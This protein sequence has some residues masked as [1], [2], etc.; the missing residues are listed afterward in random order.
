M[1]QGTDF[2][3]AKVNKFNMYGG[4]NG[5]KICVVLDGQNYMLKFPPKPK[6]KSDL[7]YTNSCFSEDI[8]CR[9]FQSLEIN[10]QKTMLGRN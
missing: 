6:Q 3:Y 9:V 4:K 8:A 7:R 2:T 1:N 10:T 5:N